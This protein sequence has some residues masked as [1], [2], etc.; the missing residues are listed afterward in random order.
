[1]S[2][3]TTNATDA[4]PA[5]RKRGQF[6]MRALVCFDLLT[7]RWS[8]GQ[9]VAGDGAVRSAGCFNHRLLSTDGILA[10]LLQPRIDAHHSVADIGA[11]SEF[12]S[13]IRLSGATS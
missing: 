1:M 10:H 13:D 6:W 5:H 11:N 8:G 4:T 7:A 2:A 3:V 9:G 12:Q